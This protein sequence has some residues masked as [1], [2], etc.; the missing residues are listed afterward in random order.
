MLP[1]VSVVVFINTRVF[2]AGQTAPEICLS[3]MR[4]I[5]TSALRT[6]FGEV[7]FAPIFLIIIIILL[8][9]FI[10]MSL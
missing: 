6:I 1:Y 3:E 10:T 4:H 9:I 8:I 7:R 5:I 2:E